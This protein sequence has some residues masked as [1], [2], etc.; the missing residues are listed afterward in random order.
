MTNALGIAGSLCCG[1]MEFAR[2]GTGAMVKR[3]HLGRAAE[4]GVLAAGLAADGFT[5]PVSIIEGEH[6]FLR[7]FCRDT[8]DAELLR[9][10]GET[11]STR[12]ILMKRFACHISAHTSVQ[13]ILDLR[14]EHGFAGTDVAAIRIAGN[15]K[16]AKV[17]NIPRPKDVMMGQYSIPFAVALA[18]FRDPRDPRSFDDGAF[19]DPAIRSLCERVTITVASGHHD[20]ATLRAEVEVELKDGRVLKKTVDDFKGTPESPLDRAGVR[21]R[22]MLLTRHCPPAAMERLLARLQNIENETSLDWLAV[23]A[24][25]KAA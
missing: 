19:N 25:A 4:S 14:A 20:H 16:M 22:F 6:G 9:G 2:S 3:L 18:H 10:L 12:T 24:A 21:E 1:L 23:E 17:N 7:V 11:W 15:E 5:G 13:A 8:D